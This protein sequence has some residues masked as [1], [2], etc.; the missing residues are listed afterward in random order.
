MEINLN[1]RWNLKCG[2]I[3][4]GMLNQGSTFTVN[5]GVLANVCRAERLKGV[6]ALFLQSSDRGRQGEGLA[7][8]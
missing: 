7:C 8:I 3:H 5:G 4:C 6:G 1:G 2:M